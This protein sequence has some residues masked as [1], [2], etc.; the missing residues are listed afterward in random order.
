MKEMTDEEKILKACEQSLQES[1]FSPNTSLGNYR[2]LMLL[3]FLI[4]GIF[5]AFFFFRF[6]VN[7]MNSSPNDKN[8][9][10]PLFL[11]S[12]DDD[13]GGGMV[14][15]EDSVIKVYDIRKDRSAINKNTALHKK[16]FQSNLK[17]LESSKSGFKE[18]EMIRK[19]DDFA[20]KK[21][22]LLQK[23]DQA[24]TRS[25]RATFIRELEHKTG[26]QH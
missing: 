9:M 10:N 26:A 2:F 23:I 13:D 21:L 14:V 20:A 7:T 11:I 24:K 6:F 19:K 3:I 25:E 1:D 4:L 17:H 22:Q 12:D 8:T 5:V 15:P 18:A 16:R